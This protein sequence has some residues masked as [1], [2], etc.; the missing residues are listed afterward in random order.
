ML[1][2]DAST[3]LQDNVLLLVEYSKP[4]MSN[5]LLFKFLLLELI[6]ETLKSLYIS[7]MFHSHV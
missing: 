2:D 3:Y 5:R 6:K 1:C 4:S 7:G